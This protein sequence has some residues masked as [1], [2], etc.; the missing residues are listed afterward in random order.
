MRW[1]MLVV[2][3]ACGTEITVRTT[4]T[5][6]PGPDDGTNEDLSPPLAVCQAQPGTTTPLTP[7]DWVGETSYDPDNNALINYRWTLATQPDGSVAELPSGQANVRAFVPDVAG[8]Y[9]ATLV[10]TD[11]VGKTSEVCAADLSAVPAHALWV[12]AWWELPGDDFDLH[13]VRGDDR[14]PPAR[15]DCYV[16]ACS[17]DWGTPGDTTDD[18]ELLQDDV[19]RVG[20]ETAA[21]FAPDDELYTVWIYDRP[22][23][24][25]TADNK[26]TVRVTLNSASMREVSHVIADEGRWVPFFQIAW[27]SGA[28]TEL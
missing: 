22:Q 13:L 18:P 11:S 3:C 5:D 8:T 15:D 21:I 10:V 20:P 25:L 19:D 2:L 12:E 28:I 7:V 6:P 1:L 4:P 17:Q 24:F 14:D 27:P 23:P 16:G 26:V 9:V